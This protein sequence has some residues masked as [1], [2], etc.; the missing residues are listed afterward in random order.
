MEEFITAMVNVPQSVKKS[1]PA[2]MKRS[3]YAGLLLAHRLRRWPNSKPT[4]AQR[5]TCLLG[6][7][8]YYWIKAT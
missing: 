1:Y 6:T 7:D 2:N 4:F 8:T 3:P 5:L